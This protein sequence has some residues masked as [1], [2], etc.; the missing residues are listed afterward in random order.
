VIEGYERGVPGMCRGA[1]RVLHVPPH[2][3]YGERGVPGVIP[4]DSTLHFTVELMTIEGEKREKT[5][6]EV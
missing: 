5:K 6:D 3:G 2:L 4:P 1:T